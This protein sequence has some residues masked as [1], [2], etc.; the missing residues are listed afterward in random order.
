MLFQ[1]VRRDFQQRFVGSAVGWIWGVIQPLVLLASW[2]FVFS[3]CLKQKMPAGEVT[4]SYPLFLFAGMLP[5]LLFSE[6]VQRSASSL[7]EQASLT[8][9]PYFPPKWCRFRSFSPRW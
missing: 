2:T 9:R 3:I 5:W 6:T 4:D 8:P 7:V 1:L